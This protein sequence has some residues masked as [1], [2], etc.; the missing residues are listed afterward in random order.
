MPYRMMS[1]RADQACAIQNSEIPN[2]DKKYGTRPLSRNSHLIANAPT[3]G[4]MMKGKSEA[5]M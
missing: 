1:N 5:L 2:C 3:T 4:V